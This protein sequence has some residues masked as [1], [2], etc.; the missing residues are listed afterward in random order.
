MRWLVVAT[1]F[2]VLADSGAGRPDGKRWERQVRLGQSVTLRDATYRW[3]LR[4]TVLSYVDPARSNLGYRPR[5]GTRFVSFLV[6]VR[7]VAKTRYQGTPVSQTELVVG[8]GA[9]LMGPLYA[10]AVIHPAWS[11]HGWTL[12]PGEVAQGH[13]SY[14]LPKATKVRAFRF[15][16]GYDVGTW[17]LRR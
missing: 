9:S 16:G 17:V 3:A 6:R 13:M 4:V 10:A 1:L 15:L 14:V 11:G 12:R 7:N 5:A 8:S 2:L